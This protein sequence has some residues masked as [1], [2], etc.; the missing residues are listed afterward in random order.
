MPPSLDTNV[1]TQS[2]LGVDE[3]ITFANKARMRVKKGQK[4]ASVICKLS[5]TIVKKKNG[6]LVKHFHGFHTLDYLI[7]VGHGITV[8]GGKFSKRSIN[9]GDGINILGGKFYKKI[10]VFNEIEYFFIKKVEEY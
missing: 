6:K 5:K 4:P 8:L 3:K 2:H 9:V 7:Q 10:Y 1:L